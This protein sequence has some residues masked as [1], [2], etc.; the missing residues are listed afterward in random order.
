MPKRK[1]RRP[2]PISTILVSGMSKAELAWLLR[3][4]MTLPRKGPI[5]IA[6]TKRSA[7]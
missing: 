4:A 1:T 5:A 2:P 3:I 6:I 7:R